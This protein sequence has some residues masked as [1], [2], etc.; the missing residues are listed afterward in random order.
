MRIAVGGD[1]T[2]PKRAGRLS[3]ITAICAATIMGAGMSALIASPAAG[4]ATVGYVRLAHLS[5]DTPEVDVYLS[6]VGDSSFERQKFPHVGYGVMSAYLAL[7]VGTYA[8]SMRL[9][10]TPE[11]EPPVL[12]NQV[13]VEDGAAYTVAGVGKNANLGIKIINDDLRRPGSGQAKVRIIQ[14]SVASPVIDVALA[15]GTPVADDVEF[16]TTTAYRLVKP[17]SWTLRLKPNGS[18]SVTTSS[19][20]L[21]AGN[22]YSLLV[23]DSE[24]GLKTEL[25][26][27]AR[28]GAS[29]PDGSVATGA[30]GSDRQDNS[31][32]VVGLALATLLVL[33][34]VAL[35]M[36]RLASRRS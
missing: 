21:G 15:D 26:R 19:A 20:N 30:G 35:T 5:P 16:A 28:G 4:A 6:K 12:T 2:H 24:N 22:V 25:R 33:V 1:V 32:L 34:S 9:A 13:T 3:R 36:R 31:L 27:D 17:G 10:D 11:S 29:A 18:S 8:V 14:A 7:P 23:L